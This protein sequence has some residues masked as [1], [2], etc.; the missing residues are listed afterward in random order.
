M[1]GPTDYDPNTNWFD[2]KAVD[3]VV[4][5]ANVLAKDA[6]VVVK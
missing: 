3:Y 1:A 2:T 4:S 6:L 5:Q